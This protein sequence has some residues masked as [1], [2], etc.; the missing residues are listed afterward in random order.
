MYLQEEALAKIQQFQ[1]QLTS[2]QADFASLA[3]QESHCSSA[4]RGGDLGEF[5]PGQMQK[6]F[7]EAT[8]ALKVQHFSL[9]CLFFCA[10]CDYSLC[11]QTEAEQWSCPTSLPGLRQCLSSCLCCIL[12]CTGLSIHHDQV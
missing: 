9:S 4:K 6:P 3:T 11:S 12:L 1:Q 2:G 7:E 10:V 5:G 8:Y